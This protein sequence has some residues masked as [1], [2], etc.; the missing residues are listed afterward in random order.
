MTKEEHIKFWLDSSADDWQTAI[1]L[2]NGKRYSLCLFSMHLSVEKLLK[3]IWIKE[4][5]ANTPPYILDFNRLSEEIKLNLTVEQIDLLTIITSWNIRGRYPDY[6]K[7]LQQ[8]AT[9]NYI[10]VQIEKVNELKGCLLEKI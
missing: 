10:K 1:Y 6:A 5:I 3:A 7:S 2:A 9:E 8:T 4:N